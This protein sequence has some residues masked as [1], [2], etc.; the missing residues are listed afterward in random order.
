MRMPIATANAA[1]RIPSPNKPSHH[2][3]A[4]P[5]LAFG[6]TLKN[7]TLSDRLLPSAGHLSILGFI[8]TVAQRRL[9]EL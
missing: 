4:S 1:G 5:G 3:A 8:A 6:R 2:V 9:D 7:S